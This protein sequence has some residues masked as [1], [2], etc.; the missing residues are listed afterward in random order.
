MLGL[1]GEVLE[2][3]SFHGK[4]QISITCELWSGRLAEVP[5][6]S[7]VERE[8]KLLMKVKVSKFCRLYSFVC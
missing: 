5:F 7:Q 6:F 8:E 3:E 2:R 1:W 4:D